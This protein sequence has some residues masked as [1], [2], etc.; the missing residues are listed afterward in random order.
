MRNFRQMT[1]FLAVFCVGSAVSSPLAFA[2]DDETTLEQY[3]KLKDQ[4]LLLKE[5]EKVEALKK[6]KNQS[7]YPQPSPWGQQPQE[8]KEKRRF[9]V[10]SVRG[11]G[12]NLTA[13]I[14][15]RSGNIFYSHAGDELPGDYTVL[16]VTGQGV[17]LVK[18]D[19]ITPIAFRVP[20][21]TKGTGSDSVQRPPFSAP[22]QFLPPMNGR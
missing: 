20:R 3:S 13:V 15:D 21:E 11:V 9:Y 5:K 16:H 12:Q 1:V 6:N 2:G 10:Y 22:P 19:K 17:D 4:E 7:P 18:G 8:K 14:V